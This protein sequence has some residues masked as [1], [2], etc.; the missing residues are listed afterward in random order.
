MEYLV[1]DNKYHLSYQGLRESYNQY[2]ALTDE[3]FRE[4]LPEILHLTCVICYLKECG[5]ESTLSDKGVIHLLVH[6][7]H[8][9][10]EPLESLQEAREA[11]ENICKLA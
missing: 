9:P 2:V 10:E 1:A 6:Q 8:I 11:F 4:K 7:L 3:E 5:N